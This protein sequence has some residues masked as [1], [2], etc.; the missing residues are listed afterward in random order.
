ME[1]HQLAYFCASNALWKAEAATARA[2]EIGP[3]VALYLRA[4]NGAA[5]N[6]GRTINR[7]SPRCVRSHSELQR[8]DCGSIPDVYL[9]APF[10]PV[11]T[12]IRGLR[13]GVVHDSKTKRENQK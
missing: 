1:L 12:G 6:H 10:H 4:V 8:T 5:N 11:E 2:S 7:A 9:L 3:G 13:F